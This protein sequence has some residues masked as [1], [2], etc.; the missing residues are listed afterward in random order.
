MSGRPS[1]SLKGLQPPSPAGLWGG[2]P[3]VTGLLPSSLPGWAARPAGRRPEQGDI[4]SE[5]LSKLGQITLGPGRRGSSPS[6]EGTA[7]DAGETPGSAGHQPLVAPSP[8]APE[9]QCP[10]PPVTVKRRSRDPRAPTAR[11]QCSG[12]SGQT[13]APVGRAEPP[14]TQSMEQCSQE[15]QTNGHC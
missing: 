8:G 4:T 9:N 14:P 15:A 10:R 2:R 1:R 13:S 11:P 6:P 7:L 12:R 3:Q 5:G